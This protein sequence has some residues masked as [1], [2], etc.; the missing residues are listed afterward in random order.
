MISSQ[1]WGEKKL[2]K[3]LASSQ[4]DKKLSVAEIT[5]AFGAVLEKK[6]KHQSFQF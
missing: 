6:W 4:M 1:V 2:G 5:F 3:D